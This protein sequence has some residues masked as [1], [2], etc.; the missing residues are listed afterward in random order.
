MPKWTYNSDNNSEINITFTGQGFVLLSH[1]TVADYRRF[2][3]QLQ[4][5]TLLL[6]P[7]IEVIYY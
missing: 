3:V 5:K 4:L 2:T 1:Y 7:A 6:T